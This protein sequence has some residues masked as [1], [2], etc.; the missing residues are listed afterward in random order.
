MEFSIL[1]SLV[2]HVLLLFSTAKSDPRISEA[3]HVCDKTLHSPTSNFIPNFVTLMQAISDQINRN[4]WGEANVTSPPPE[5]YA[6]AQCHDDLSPSDCSACFAASRTM[7]P[8][9]L[10]SVSAR[11]FLDG[12][13]L[14]YDN[15]SFH[16]ESV[17]VD[18]AGDDRDVSKCGPPSAVAGD[19]FLRS[20]FAKKVKDV[21]GVLAE[22]AAINGGFAVGE[23]RGGVA[24]VYAMAQCWKTV[25]KED[26]RRCLRAAGDRI[27][28]CPP[29][30]E[31]RAMFAGCYLRYST[32]RFFQVSAKHEEELDSATVSMIIAGV[33]SALAFVLLTL[34]GAY[35]GL[36]TVSSN[37]KEDFQ[38]EIPTALQNSRLNFKYEMLE[39]ATDF[40]DAS[41][42]LG[43]GG[44]G[45]VFK[46]IL[47]D[48]RIVAVK[49]LFF[50]TTQW[51]DEFFNEVNLISGIEHKNLVKL[52]G[53]SIE[54][55]ESLLVY[56]FVPNKSLDQIIFDKKNPANVLS[57]Q[58][59][60]NIISGTAEGLA[61]L[62]GG[63]GVKIIHRDIKTSNILLGENLNPKIADFGLARSVAT[64]R[65]HIST[66]IAGTLGYMA[67]EYLVRGQLTDK[68]DVYAY[69]V[70]I[71]EIVSSRKNS[72]FTLG[73]SSVLHSVWKLYKANKVVESVD[74]AL[75]DD[76]PAE[77]ASNVLQIG[78]LC[79][80]ASVALRP[81]MSEVVQMLS[82]REHEIPLPMQPP[83]LNASIL[84]PDDSR[85]NT[86]QESAV[87]TANS[88]T[89][90]ESMC[91][92]TVT[93]KPS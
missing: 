56:E 78:L 54:G 18:G 65:T 59:R 67:P 60:F 85:E 23:D 5:I 4:Q 84:N 47:P 27:G 62:H 41:R 53:C 52:L 16:G 73:S 74:P 66:G 32:E 15:Y 22:T 43:Q 45:S 20:E 83:F 30:A 81:S 87:Y 72:A 34:T 28:E 7:L 13:F 10:P 89:I 12:C 82:D 44:A 11:I 68:A 17:G 24:D 8:K 37:K 55:P 51:V 50:N 19:E 70:L 57:W 21:V 26:C 33:L 25:E 88:N 93:S 48:G 69:G 75:K 14:R 71:L 63:C 49:R 29:A 39:K 36:K 86:A 77:E 6:F 58:Q 3:A 90:Y 9:C 38:T 76:F 79:T 80:Q 91:E 35:F 42:K 40:F 31:G 46:G 2:F 64:D 1:I 61:Y 92:L